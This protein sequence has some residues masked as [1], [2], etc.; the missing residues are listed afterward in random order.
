MGVLHGN[1]TPEN[2]LLEQSTGRA[3]LADFGLFQAIGSLASDVEGINASPEDTGGMA[4]DGSDDLVALGRIGRQIL[5]RMRAFPADAQ[6]VEPRS[7][8][9][10]AAPSSDCLE[11]VRRVVARLA[12]TEPENR[13]RT[14][15]EARADLTGRNPD[16]RRRQRF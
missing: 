1:L 9:N 3:M 13:Y 11:T 5:A 12:A 10:V 16:G 6:A 4:T 15:A 2:I 8:S 14:A 7:L